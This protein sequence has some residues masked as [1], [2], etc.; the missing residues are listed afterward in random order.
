MAPRHF[1]TGRHA[2]A[3]VLLPL[4]RGPSYGLE[5]LS[6]LRESLATTSLDG[7][8]VYRTL[9]QLERQGAVSGTWERRDGSRRRW[10]RLTPKGSRMLDAFEED[11]RLRMA[12]FSFFL[13]FRKKHRST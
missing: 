11:V 8:G 7:P 2:P 6:F 5:I 13:D 12:N 4:T 3:F 10:Y 9:R 1:R